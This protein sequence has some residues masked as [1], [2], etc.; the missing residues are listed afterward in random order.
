MTTFLSGFSNWKEG[1]LTFLQVISIE[2]VFLRIF[3]LE[4]QHC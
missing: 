3:C 4:Y 2:V 1:I